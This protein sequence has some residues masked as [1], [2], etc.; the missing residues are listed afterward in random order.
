MSLNLERKMRQKPKVERKE[1]EVIVFKSAAEE[2]AW[3]ISKMCENPVRPQSFHSHFD[4]TAF[5]M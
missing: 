4:N 3:R 5:M 2:Q 1:K